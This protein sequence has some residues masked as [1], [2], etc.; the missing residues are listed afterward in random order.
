MYGFTTQMKVPF[1]SAAGLRQPQGVT[2]G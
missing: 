2:P 1:A